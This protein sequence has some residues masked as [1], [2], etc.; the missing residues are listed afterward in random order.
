MVDEIR[1]TDK[2][3]LITGGYTA[4]GMALARGFARAGADVGLIAR[5]AESLEEAAREIRSLGVRSEPLV[6]DITDEPQ[7]IAAFEKARRDLGR[8]DFLVNNTGIPGPLMR[9]ENMDVAEWRRIIDVNLTGIMLCCR[10]AV[11]HMV[12][13][14]GGN[15][16]NI[17]ST[18]G[19]R[20]VP[21][22][23]AYSASKWGM[24]GLTQT[25]ALESGRQNIRVNCINLGSI[26]GPRTDWQIERRSKASG[27]TTEELARRRVAGTSLGRLVTQDEFVSLA[28]FLASDLSSGMTGQS[29]NLSAGDTFH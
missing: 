9:I 20:G 19:K 5:T 17:S 18:A 29:I 26:E 24:S 7:V 25:L 15:I 12:P 21:D 16:V 6:A 22:S 13:Q 27:I 3:A 2:V 4:L 10:E 1:L 14:G 28:L 11:R 23:G 8:I